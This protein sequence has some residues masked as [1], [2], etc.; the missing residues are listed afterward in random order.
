MT[1]MGHPDPDTN[2]SGLGSLRFF[3]EFT[4]SVANMLRMTEM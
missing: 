1:R 3:A 2:V 4:L